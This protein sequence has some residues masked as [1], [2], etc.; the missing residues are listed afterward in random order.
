MVRR[1]KGMKKL[2]LAALVLFVVCGFVFAG[3][4]KEAD[5]EGIVVGFSNASISNSWRVFM[6]AN[7]EYEVSLHPEITEY[8]YTDADDKPEK[9]IAD[10]DDL[11]VKGIDVLIIS[12]AVQDAVNP[13]IEKAY[14]MG[15][16][17]IVFDSRLYRMR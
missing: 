8:Y 3:G 9:Q 13:A 17:V 5:K 11:L 16:P 14:D 6:K 12:P 1:R 4:G 2:L 7:L 10:V 15:I